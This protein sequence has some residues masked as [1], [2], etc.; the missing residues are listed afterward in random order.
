MTGDKIM[1]FKKALNTALVALVL[2]IPLEALSQQISVINRPR[3]ST[4]SDSDVRVNP[5]RTPVS[6]SAITHCD[7]SQHMSHAL[8]RSLMLDEDG[9]RVEFDG[10]DL[11]KAR[12]HV[13]RHYS[14][15][16]DLEVGLETDSRNNVFVSFRNTMFEDEINSRG[17][18]VRDAYTQY[19]ACL[20]DEGVMTRDGDSLQVD[21]S[22][23]NVRR[24]ESRE[25]NF[26]EG[27]FNKVGNVH[28]HYLG[29]GENENGGYGPVFSDSFER[30]GCYTK[31]SLSPDGDYI[32]YESPEN[33]A[34]TMAYEACNSGDVVNILRALSNL[35]ESEVGNARELQLILRQALNEELDKEG[36]RIY[37]RMREIGRRFEF[38][39]GIPKLSVEDAAEYGDE[40]LSLLHDLNRV[41]LNPYISF[42]DELKDERR[43][44]SPERRELIDAQ[45]A[46][47]NKKIQQYSKE[48]RRYGYDAVMNTMRYYAD[49]LSDYARDIE[50]FNLKSH[51]YGR[52]YAEGRSNDPRG[53]RITSKENVDDEIRNR[54]GSFDRAFERF[55]MEDATRRRGD[56]SAVQ[57][58]QNRV[59]TLTSARDRRWQEDIQKVQ[60]DFQSCVGWFHT[61]FKIQQCQERM[62]RAYNQALRRREGYNRQ[63]QGAGEDLTNY[64]AQY[65]IYQRTQA[66]RREREQD[67]SSL[68][69]YEQDSG[70][71]IQSYGLSNPGNYYSLM[72]GAEGG[73]GRAPAFQFSQQPQM[74]QGFGGPMQHGFTTQMPIQQQMPMMQQQMP[75]MQQQSPIMQ[76]GPGGYMIP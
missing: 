27:T 65:Q 72:G 35:E 62:Q 28:V 47:Y 31:E 71:G 61:Q 32:A 51:F 6:P 68:F 52:Y 43:Y 29:P 30:M 36:E 26:P 44:A 70:S 46:E 56:T 9:I 64:T 15:C 60:Q 57:R 53:A 22:K 25:F 13:P 3:P 39:D 75:M 49:D 16:L 48:G 1:K 19:L 33:R 4:S 73:L 7:S 34:A 18:V 69:W 10:D 67:Q 11:R 23:M 17:E 40:Y 24:Y 54:L 8:L 76:P 20:E 74:Q 63:I 45:I 58:S 42:I 38:E 41:I 59:T 55:A 2:V 14:T 66:Q 37:N 5:A 12:V 50:G 21:A